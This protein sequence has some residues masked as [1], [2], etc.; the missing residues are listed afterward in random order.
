MRLQFDHDTWVFRYHVCVDI[1]DISLYDD[2]NEDADGNSDADRKLN[3]GHDDSDNVL[4]VDA[5]DL[6][7]DK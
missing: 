6:T 7:I 3:I 5:I 4:V 1:I 2:S